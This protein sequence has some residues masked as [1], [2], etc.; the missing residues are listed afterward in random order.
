MRYLVTLLV[1]LF[2]LP[3]EAKPKFR[4]S[5]GVR[6]E[7]IEVVRSGI[8]QIGERKSSKDASIST[9]DLGTI[10]DPKIIKETSTIVAGDG[11]IHFGAEVRLLGVEKDSRVKLRV[12][13]RYPE[14]GIVN[15]QTGVAKHVDEFDDVFRG[16]KIGYVSW[17]MID[18]FVK[19]PGKWT[20]ELWQ[21]DRQLMTYDFMIVKP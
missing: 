21:D 11:T 17:T 10:S 15:P 5:D 16:G 12:V 7:R 18:D 3:A 14:P 4:E 8:L 13:W 20:V 6:V 2:A 19:V 9:G 1:L